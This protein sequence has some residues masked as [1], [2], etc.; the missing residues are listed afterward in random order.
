MGPDNY[1][2]DTRTL[3]RFGVVK[4]S[5]ARHKHVNFLD[6]RTSRSFYHPGLT[7]RYQQLSGAN[8]QELGAHASNE[9]VDSSESDPLEDIHRTL[10]RPEPLA[11]AHVDQPAGQAGGEATSNEAGATTSPA[12]PTII[13]EGQIDNGHTVVVG[14]PMHPLARAAFAALFRRHEASA[15]SG[16]KWSSC[17]L[18]GSAP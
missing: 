2:V 13:P 5:T 7:R 11:P 18:F 1:H 6:E 4:A 10:S 15:D 12:N 17:S 16:S 9:G 3:S 8:F 14:Q